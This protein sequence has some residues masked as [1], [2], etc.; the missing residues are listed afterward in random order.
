MPVSKC[1]STRELIIIY[2]KESQRIS[3]KEMFILHVYNVTILSLLSLSLDLR[4][5][6]ASASTTAPHINMN[7]FPSLSLSVS[8]SL[9]LS[10]SLLTSILYS[11][12]EE[13]P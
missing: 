6:L 9:S 12:L 2:S 11:L 5:L 1:S 8:L 7:F 10:L 13:Y 3:K 4:A